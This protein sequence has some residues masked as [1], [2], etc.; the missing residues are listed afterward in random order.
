MENG[1]G[2]FLGR[3]FSMGLCMDFRNVDVVVRCWIEEL[4]VFVVGCLK[5]VSGSFCELFVDCWWC[6]I[7]LE[8]LLWVFVWI[9]VEFV[10]CG[11]RCMV[12]MLK[13]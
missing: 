5:E 8:E 6:K 1:F 7:F 11:C 12:W 2:K 10:V 13:L 9:D 3:I 4:E